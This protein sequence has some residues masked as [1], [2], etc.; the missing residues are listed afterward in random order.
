MKAAGG[1]LVVRP[2]RELRRKNIVMLLE[3]LLGNDETIM[4][5]EFAPNGVLEGG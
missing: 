3:A 1:E 2:L 5:A 4:T